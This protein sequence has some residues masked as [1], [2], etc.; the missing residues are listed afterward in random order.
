[1]KMK[2]ASL[3]V[4]S[5]ERPDFT[6][7]SIESLKRNTS[8]PHELIVNDDA[9]ADVYAIGYVRGLFNTK[10]LSHLILNAGS[11]MGVG[12]SFR[13]CIGVSSGEFIFKLD[14]DL[15]YLPGWLTTVTN[16]LENNPDVACCGLFNYRHYDRND[17]R[18]E[19][20]EEREDCFIVT[21]FV[22]SGY[23][24]KREIFEK[25]G[26]TLGDDGWQQYVKDQGHLLA[27]PKVDVVYNFGFGK[28][29]VYVKDGKVREVS[30][31]PLIFKNE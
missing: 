24:F 28:N 13:N 3:C 23:G 26:H 31:D 15:E 27:I 9:S 30:K 21:D 16:I 18:F 8:Y 22:N 11:N 12:K 10:R 19:I 20:I 1:M 29:S 17:T 7:K 14:A 25:Y 5:F 4:L 2:F 6:R